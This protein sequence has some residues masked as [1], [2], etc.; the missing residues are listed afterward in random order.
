MTFILHFFKHYFYIELR[1][2]THSLFK[3]GLHEGIVHLTNM[4]LVL[5]GPPCVG[6]TS[7][8]SLLFK[9]PSPKVHN[10]TAL[11]TRPI[12][13]I[14]RVA[15]RNEG[16]IWVKI[17]GLDLLQMLSD[18]ILAIE[19]ESGEDDSHISEKSMKP[20]SL[21][22]PES[23]LCDV[24]LID[25]NE[26]NVTLEECNITND[27][28]SCPTIASSIVSSFST[29]PSS[30][31]EELVKA[32][33]DIPQYTSILSE[34]DTNSMPPS[35][36][37]ASLSKHKPTVDENT[38]KMVELLTKQ[39]TSKNRHKAT[40][41]NVLD[42][43]G[44][45]QFADVSRAFIRGNTMNIIC[46][47][48][49]ES[50][51]DKPKFCYS[52]N[53]KL[54]SQPSE[55]QMTNLQLIEHFVRSIVASKNTFKVKGNKRLP[56]FMIIG[57][58]YDKIKGSKEKAF[59]SLRAKNELLLS[60]L[61]EFRDHFIFSSND[62]EELIFPVDN[63]CW[64]NR[65]KISSSFRQLIMSYQ[66]DIGISLPI[67]VRWY[68]FEMRLKEEASQEEHG[69]IS[70]ETCYTIGVNFSMNQSDVLKSIMYLQSMA[71]F[72][73]F[74]AVLPNVIFTNP[75]YLLDM[76]SALIRVSFVN[77]LEEILPEGQ[78]L[79]PEAQHMFREDGVFDSSLLDKVCF[80]FVS[81]LFSAQQ[82]LNLLRYLRIVAPLSSSDVQKK[83]FMPVVL[84]PQQMTEEHIA[85]F[86][87]TCDPM[88]V[89]FE[90]KVVPQVG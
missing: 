23:K 44:Q 26:Q 11:A 68:M 60:I 28:V 61:Y 87:R 56:L 66:T 22:D 10:S 67:P 82:L 7:F 31:N 32:T 41:I 57:T 15:E 37:Q 46:T 55:L 2:A 25:T 52:L 33:S 8:K 72:L 39:N 1:R 45:P 43:G 48:L 63:M 77:S 27:D 29:L 17:T 64:W 40:W 81:S 35:P 86:K 78:S 76:L 89:A 24:F 49:T 20:V 16:K 9:W 85:V 59:E 50:L 34:S 88:V 13:A 53:G 80:P 4:R 51:S 69:M 18:A 73:F 54:L 12:R 42:S 14:E 84:P 74:P 65:K 19:K 90:T 58:F 62:P 38:T 30:K 36:K 3:R 71:L 75:Q 83:Y 47:K 21:V 5:M 79:E 70:L 6:K